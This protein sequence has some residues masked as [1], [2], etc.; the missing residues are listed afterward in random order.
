MALDKLAHG[1][2]SLDDAEHELMLDNDTPS[3]PGLTQEEVQLL[4]RVSQAI[5]VMADLSRADVLLFAACS[6][7]PHSGSVASSPERP[8]EAARIVAEAKPNAVPSLYSESLRGRI[9]TRYDEPVVFRVWD[10]RK[11]AF[12]ADAAV[13][14]MPVTEEAYPLL[15]NHT[16]IG[17]LSVRSAPLEYER[18]RKKDPIWKRA[19][20]ELR[21]M[22][23]RGQL[24]GCSNLTPMGEHDGLLVVDAKGKIKYLSTIAEH[25]YRKVGYREHMLNTDLATLTTNEGVFYKALENG[26][27]VEQEVHEGAMIW[28]RKAVPILVERV[29]TQLQSRVLRKTEYTYSGAILVIADLTEERQKA[30]ELHIKS[31]MIREIHHRVKNNLQTI[32][33]LLRLQARRSGSSEVAAMLHQTINRILSIA[34]VHE[35]LSQDADTIVNLREVTERI[36]QE[37]KLSIVDPEK[38]I[39]I[40]LLCDDVY[41]GAQQATSCALVLNELV[42]NA[43]EHGIAE[44]MYGTI[45]ITLAEEEHALILTVLDDGSG[46]PPTFNLNQSGN[47]GLQIV[48]TLVRNDLKGNFSLNNAAQTGG[49]Y[50]TSAIVKFP[51]LYS[52]CKTSA[53]TLTRRFSSLVELH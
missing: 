40:D 52:D 11:A 34:V 46:L 32:A 24:D 14:G 2:H 38:K 42:Q 49:A 30:E 37:A 8:L 48:Q 29:R 31:T 27:C 18:Q 23:L 47:L 45:S 28:R 5:Q 39:Q 35:Q 26:V 15:H 53:H 3:A 19:V 16:V 43:L 50:T 4:T 22:I 7:T 17:V 1:Q 20:A 41:L 36:I 12:E 6:P 25:L 21:Q 33:S 51:K 9:V 13:M 10:R 44:R